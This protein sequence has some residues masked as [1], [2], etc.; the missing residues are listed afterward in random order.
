LLP[1]KLRGPVP[2]APESCVADPEA[3]GKV[4]DG[5]S[6]RGER[7]RKPCASCRPPKET[8]PSGSR[9]DGDGRRLTLFRPLALP[10]NGR[11][12]LSLALSFGFGTHCARPGKLP[13]HG[14]MA[15]PSAGT[16]GPVFPVTASGAG[17]G[18]ALFLFEAA[19]PG[20]PGPSFRA[21]ST[22]EESPGLPFFRSRGLRRPRERIPA[23]VHLISERY[24]TLAFF[25]SNTWPDRWFG[26]EL[27]TREYREKERELLI[28]AAEKNKLRRWGRGKG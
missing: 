19:R 27:R 8:L 2:G 20:L 23:Y 16:S 5:L 6:R 25:F 1:E 11:G 26:L 28:E 14:R 24:L 12:I 21:N 15:G 4:A 7:G 13:F 22:R 17:L 9:I 10:G 18:R 3:S